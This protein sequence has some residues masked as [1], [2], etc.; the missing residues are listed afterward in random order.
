MQGT[1]ASEIAI[2]THLVGDTHPRRSWAMR[3]LN[4]AFGEKM[5]IEHSQGMLRPLFSQL[6]TDVAQGRIQL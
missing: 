5:D 4:W 2:V 6:S 1:G 3:I